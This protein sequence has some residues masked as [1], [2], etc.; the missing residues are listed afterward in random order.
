MEGE[1]LCLLGRKPA[2]VS[3]KTGLATLIATHRSSKTGSFEFS[4]PDDLTVVLGVG[5][6]F[7]IEE[8]EG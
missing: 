4:V 7:G 8:E 3:R 5:G 2:A 1:T 6:P